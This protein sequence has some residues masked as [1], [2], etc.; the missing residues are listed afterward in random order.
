MD[1]RPQLPSWHADSELTGLASSPG[2]VI[3]SK[4]LSTQSKLPLDPASVQV[5]Q[6]LGF[7]PP[8]TDLH[9]GEPSDQISFGSFLSPVSPDSFR[10]GSIS[11]PISSDIPRR[12]PSFHG[13]RYI[14]G[15]WD[16]IPDDT[17]LSILD[18]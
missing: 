7:I 12:F 5:Q 9:P 17:L 3:K 13:E 2:P 18:G 8:P 10:I 6:K 1:S 16:S 14:V 4:W 11:L 15:L